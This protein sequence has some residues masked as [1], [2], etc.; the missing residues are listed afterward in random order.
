MANCVDLSW[1]N[2]LGGMGALSASMS[3]EKSYT[4]HPYTFNLNDK[5]VIH[6]RA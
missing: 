3:R 2:I 4:S 1:H 6:S 5:L